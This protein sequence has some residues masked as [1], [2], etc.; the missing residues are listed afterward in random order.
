MGGVVV[1]SSLVPTEGSPGGGAIVSSGVIPPATVAGVLAVSG[2]RLACPRVVG[3]M[4]EE[5]LAANESC[6]ATK[7]RAGAPVRGAAVGPPPR[8]ESVLEPWPERNPG[9]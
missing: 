9:Q 2:A 4:D 5:G 1:D 7:G 8:R 6:W 3:R